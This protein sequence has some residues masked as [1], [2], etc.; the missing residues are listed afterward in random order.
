V[1]QARRALSPPPSLLIRAAFAYAI[2]TSTDP[3]EGRARLRRQASSMGIG[4]QYAKFILQ[5][6]AE[7]VYMA[8]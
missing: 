7:L 3:S 8:N 4:H 5:R 6:G 1:E 2:G